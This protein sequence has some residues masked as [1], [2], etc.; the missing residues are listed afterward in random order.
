MGG[1]GIFKLHRLS[2]GRFKGRC[3]LRLFFRDLKDSLAELSVART[4]LH[5]DQCVYNVC[6]TKASVVVWWLQEAL[7]TLVLLGPQFY[8]FIKSILSVWLQLTKLKN[9]IC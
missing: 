9:G 5:M 7:L 1:S 6:V 3:I 8:R 2:G 4:S